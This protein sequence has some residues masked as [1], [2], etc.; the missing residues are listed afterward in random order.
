M[1]TPINRLPLRTVP[2]RDHRGD[3]RGFWGSRMCQACDRA[4][5]AVLRYIQCNRYVYRW[6]SLLIAPPTILLSFLLSDFCLLRHAICTHLQDKKIKV[7]L[8]LQVRNISFLKLLLKFPLAAHSG[9]DPASGRLFR[10][11]HRRSFATEC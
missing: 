11:E 8:F 9:P 5:I 3:G 6:R 1:P 10:F 7:S 2:Q 4:Y